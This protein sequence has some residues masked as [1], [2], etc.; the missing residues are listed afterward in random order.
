VLL[1]LLSYVN[2]GKN[3]KFGIPDSEEQKKAILKTTGLYSFSRN[4]MYVGFFLMTIASCLYVLN[5]LIWVLSLFTLIVH[6]LIVLKEEN[7]LKQTFDKEWFEYSK[8]VQRYV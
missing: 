8:K 2:L 5:P 3:L 6:H 1:Q 4:P 7:F